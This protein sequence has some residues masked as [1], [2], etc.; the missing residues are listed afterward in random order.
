MAVSVLVL[1]CRHFQSRVLQWLLLVVLVLTVACSAPTEQTVFDL[2]EPCTSDEGP[3]DGFCGTFDVAENPDEPSGKMIALKVVVLPALD[4][5]PAPDPVFFLAGGPGQGSA[6]LA[7]RIGGIFDPIRRKRDIVFVDQ[8]GTGESNRLVCEFHEDEEWIADPPPLTAEDVDKCIEQLDGDPR[9]YTTTVAMDDL[10]QVRDWLGYERINPMGVSYGTRAA[11]VYLK[12]HPEQVRSVI[13]DV[14]APPDMALG[15]H[16]PRDA[17][18]ALDRLTEACLNSDSCNSRFPELGEKLDRLLAE[19]ERSPRQLTITHPRTGEEMEA[20]ISR[21]FLSSTLFGALYSPWTGSLVPLAIDRAA[22]GDYSIWATLAFSGEG[23][24][25][26]MASGMH[27]AVICS[28]DYPRW[29]D[30]EMEDESGDSFVGRHGF[31]DRWQACEFWPRGEVDESF[32]EPVVSELPV[33]ILSG[34]IDPITPPS[35][36]D[37]VAQH[38]PNSRHIIAPGTGHGVMAVGCAMRLI[39]QFL[40]EETASNLD[41]SCLDNQARPPFFLN[42][43]GPYSPTE[44]DSDE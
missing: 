20:T 16:A 39:V 44:E 1:P 17:Q 21:R 27:L 31:N 30:A 43:T 34:D 4:S 36:G 12:R 5:E 13:L 26:E 8:R 15:L 38:L 14:V 11:L 25:D 40:D 33:L 19:L 9:F 29:A 42:N 6:S 3:S 35:W 23:L 37:H 10:D 22:T 7:A 32:Y 28:E 41:A 18:R 2:L 24:E